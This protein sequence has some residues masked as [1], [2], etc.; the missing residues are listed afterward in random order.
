[1][2]TGCSVQRFGRVDSLNQVIETVHSLG[3]LVFLGEEE[4]AIAVRT[5]DGEAVLVPVVA[6]ERRR[7]LTVLHC[8]KWLLLGRDRDVVVRTGIQE[9]GID[10]FQGL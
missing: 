1:M 6:P 7:M 5:M 4:S 9:L 10:V 3:S 2:Q 8:K